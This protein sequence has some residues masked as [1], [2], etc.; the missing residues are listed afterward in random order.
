MSEE[1]ERDVVEMVQSPGAV[2]VTAGGIPSEVPEEH[3]I[4]TAIQVPAPPHVH[5]HPQTHTHVPSHT[6]VEKPAEP[7]TQSNQSSSGSSEED[8]DESETEGD[9]GEDDEDADEDDEEVNT[10]T[11]QGRESLLITSAG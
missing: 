11:C 10:H 7:S 3:R 5:G 6:A 8:E 2:D 1:S 9:D 4:V